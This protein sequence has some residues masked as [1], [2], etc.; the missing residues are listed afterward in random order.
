MEHVKYRIFLRSVVAFRKIYRILDTCIHQVAFDSEVLLIDFVSSSFKRTILLG[1]EI[2][3]LVVCDSY[4]LPL[5][6]FNG[7]LDVI[8]VVPFADRDGTS[9]D[10]NLLISE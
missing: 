3:L 7:E 10:I 6:G 9:V 5:I 2:Y 8:L 4:E 1:L